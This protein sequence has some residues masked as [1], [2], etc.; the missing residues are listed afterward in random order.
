MIIC[1]GWVGESC[2]M[3]WRSEDNSKYSG[4]SLHL[5]MSSRHQTQVARLVW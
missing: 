1:R 5:S 4:L 3:V 2:A